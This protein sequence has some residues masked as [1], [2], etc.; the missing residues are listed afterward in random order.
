MEQAPKK[1]ENRVF[2]PPG[3][4]KTSYLARQIKRA[5][6]KYGPE[7]VIVASFTRTAAAEIAGR[8]LPLGRAQV[9]TLHSHCYRALGCPDIAE[10]RRIKDWNE[11]YP[12]YRLSEGG[13]VDVDDPYA[14]ATAYEGTVGDQ[15]LAEYQSLRA[16]MVPREVWPL[17]V[18]A[19]AEAWED[20]KR[21]I[22][23][24]D[25][26]DLIE[27][28]LQDIPTAP[29][30]P[31]V[32]FFDEVQDFTALELALVRKWGSR[33]EY[34]ILAGDDDQCIYGFKG[35]TPD[36]FL[37]PEI[38]PENKRILSQSHRVPRAVQALAQDWIVRVQRR[39]PKEYRPRDAVGD[40][41]R[42]R[43]GTWKRPEPLCEL[44]AELAEQGKTV[45]IL[46]ACS[47]MLQ[48]AIQVL[49]KAGVP[50]HNPFREKRGDW[51]PLRRGG[52]KRLTAV[53]RLLAFLRMD[54]QTWGEQAR[55]W[56]GEDVQ[57]W[58]EILR[59]E[60]VFHRG[61]RQ[62]I[63]AWPLDA[64]APLDQ[65]ASIMEEDAF[66]HAMELDLDWYLASAQSSRQK[67]LEY[68]VSVAKRFGGRALREEPKVVVGTIHSVKGGQA[69][70]VILFPDLSRQGY[71][72]WQRRDR[73]DEVIRQFYVGM[74]RARESLIIA[75]PV[76]PLSVPVWFEAARYCTNP[77]PW[78][79]RIA[80]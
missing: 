28:A 4:G 57:R 72:A 26:T 63:A 30:A 45:M 50:F 11:H 44:A 76:G 7:G 59:Q 41:I 55:P 66:V 61:M 71:E 53:D 34:L 33:M 64:E 68:P 38:P 17:R 43:S 46:A 75:P 70:V 10:V 20:W 35:A 49:R 80:A 67:A 60:G 13:A 1:G 37:T 31:A 22:N 65:L 2:G 3:T 39:E 12:Q 14:D 62:V 47:Y 24:M 27:V 9:G 56:T 74:T 32:G 51:N 54:Y 16:R 18:K 52:G 69:D 23:C 19:F 15:L 42:A 21:G 6:E 58:S 29:G 78:A 48:P 79:V 8:Q 77:P 73:R 40:V 25:F 36:A 5:V